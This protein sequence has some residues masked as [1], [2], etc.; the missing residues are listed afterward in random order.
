MAGSELPLQ[1]NN[2]RQ[3]WFGGCDTAW[4]LEMQLTNRQASTDCARRGGQRPRRGG[5]CS[6]AVQVPTLLPTTTAADNRPAHSTRFSKWTMDSPSKRS[7]SPRRHNFCFSK[8]SSAFSS[9][10][11]VVLDPYKRNG[12]S[13]RTCAATPQFAASR[14]ISGRSWSTPV[15]MS[16]ANSLFG[17]VLTTRL[18]FPDLRIS[19]RKS[20]Q[21]IP[22]ARRCSRNSPRSIGNENSSSLATPQSDDS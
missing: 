6:R 19:Q 12:H 18:V 3:A 21:S 5:F 22:S 8:C 7:L 10:G 20:L 4:G 1:R 17:L 9:P 16:P 2:A 13:R 14:R 11:S 15:S